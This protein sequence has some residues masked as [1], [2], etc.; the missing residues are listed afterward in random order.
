MDRI[1]KVD[2]CGTARQILNIARRGETVYLLCE[3]IEIRLDETHELL[4][5]VGIPLPLQDLAEP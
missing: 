5:I 3:E 2:R 1:R 4:V